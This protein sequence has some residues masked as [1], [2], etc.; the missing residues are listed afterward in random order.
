MEEY[1]A[2]IAWKRWFKNGS[3]K[4]F[5]RNPVKMYARR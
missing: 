2:L 4:Y 1:I 3:R 5:K